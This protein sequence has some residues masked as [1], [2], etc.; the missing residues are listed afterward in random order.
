MAVGG[1]VLA[2]LDW[3]VSDVG[4]VMSVDSGSVGFCWAETS[5]AAAVVLDACNEN[6]A[7]ADLG[8]DDDASGL[9]S[10]AATKI[11]RVHSLCT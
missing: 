7:R 8:T 10:T 3:E 11:P 9:V 1:C 2:P 4:R 6:R 5:A